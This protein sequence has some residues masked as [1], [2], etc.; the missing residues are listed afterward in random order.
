MAERERERG[1]SGAPERD[2]LL[3]TKVA[4]PRIRPGLLTRSSLL[5]ALDQAAVRELTVVCTPPGFGKTTLLAQWA[6]LAQ[7]RVAWLSLDPDDSDPVRFWRYVVA[8]LD[9]AGI[10]TGARV[11]PLLQAPSGVS[12]ET[13]VTVLINDL[14]THPEETTVVLDDYHTVGSR[15]VHDGISFLLDHLPSWL[16]L[17]VASRSDPPLPVAS[18]RAAGK[19]AELRDA[20]LRFTSQESATFLREVWDLDLSQEAVAA[21]DRRTEGWAVGLQLAALSLQRRSD[22]GHFVEAFTGTNRYVIDYLSE[23]VLKRQ[24]D[25]V[26]TFLLECSILERLSSPLCNAVTGGS[27]G[28][29]ML[30]KL[31]RA[32]LFLVPLDDERRWYR[33]HHLFGDLLRAQLQRVQPG[34]APELYRKAA[35]WCESHDLTDDAIRYALKAGDMTSA[36]CLVEEHLGQTLRRG[37]S[38]TLQ[39]W[40]S[41][42]PDEAVK[43]SPALCV[44]LGLMELHLGHL[45]AVDRLIDHAEHG[46]DQG[47]A[48]LDVEVPTDGGMVGEV[49]AALAILRS[50]LASARGRPEPTNE[51]ATSALAQMAEDERGPRLWGRWLQFLAD[52]MDGR[53]E[54][55]ESGFAQILAE[56][57][58]LPDPHPLTTSCHTLGWVQ[59]ARGELT[60]G[61]RT[62]QEGL[63]YA[64][65][66]GRFVSFHSGEAHIGIA[67]VL[68]ARNELDD[69]L[70][71]VTSGIDLVRQVVEFQLPAFGQVT[72]AWIL[73]ALGQSEDALEAMNDACRLLPR[74]DVVTMFS[75]A[76]TERARLWLAQGRIDQ[77]MRWAVERGLSADDAPSYPR[78][79]DHLVL[80][81]VLLARSEPKRALGLLARLDALAES[82]GRIGSLIEIRALRSL[83][84][85][86]VADH[87]GALTALSE[88][89]SM[90]RPEG[91]IRVFADEGAP[92]ASLL[93]SLIRARGRGWG[94]A[95]SRAER[96]H[97]NR[98]VRAFRAPVGHP[99]MPEAARVAPGSIEPLTRRE[100]D[101]LGSMA[102]GRRNQQIADEL[103]IT[104]ETVKRHVSHI[105]NK[106]GAA[107]RMEAVATARDLHLIP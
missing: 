91:Y 103:V 28:Q 49:P 31:E 68:Y 29:S 75:P 34:R 67:Q 87:P 30:E 22:P 23:E 53:M 85:Q 99:E 72:L 59:Q 11:K 98:V 79:R 21:L 6:Q 48:P 61:L 7:G 62:Y 64:R 42:L 32:N 82:H 4:I 97:L 100:L 17:V 77:A 70:R 95:I 5:E 10:L 56:A 12:S 96:E 13:I 1:R 57:R 25:P 35:A 8:A 83:A 105:L 81:R 94:T 60:R 15:S 78:E 106:L 2:E 36:K 14:E 41:A 63:R 86:S 84:L 3:S 46:F 69:A 76:Q 43:S 89:L 18:L 38:V 104:L 19:L 71:H 65:A 20:D 73:H 66:G 39:R 80:A 9:R 88:A 107:N 101:V 58:T 50:E 90:A 52:W 33:F 51:Y 47:Q 37:E 92:M 26:R 27:D 24:P 55:A 102:A 44:A 16:H 54:R 93:Q 74:S 40:L 45:E